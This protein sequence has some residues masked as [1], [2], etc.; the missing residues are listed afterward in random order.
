MFCSSCGQ[1]LSENAAF[2]TACGAPVNAVVN[3]DP[4]Q[5]DL[6]T[7]FQMQKNAIRQSE[8]QCL[9]RAISY[10]SEKKNTFDEYYKTADTIQVHSRKDN[11]S[12]LIGIGILLCVLSIVFLLGAMR[13]LLTGQ[14]E[15][16]PQTG[17][18]AITAYALIVLIPLV[19][20]L[21]M[22]IRGNKS[23]TRHRE[24]H[25]YYL[26][27]HQALAE[28]L[29]NHYMRYPSCPVGAQYCNPDVLR[30][31]L[32]VLESGRADTV[33]EALNLM[34]NEVKSKNNEAYLRSI[35]RNTEAIFIASIFH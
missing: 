16:E 5:E 23:K 7:Q 19:I 3:T 35:E 32:N 10:F 17:A 29:H 11:S 20:G 31:I 22:L 12:T 25:E 30:I 27:R 14:Y 6:K 4:R 9:K 24:K 2:C 33:K 1:K 26:Q 13:T 34:I 28:E 8:I 15:I 18:I 21:I